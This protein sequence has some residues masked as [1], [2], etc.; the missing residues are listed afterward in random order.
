MNYV[1]E[2]HK[3]LYLVQKYISIDDEEDSHDV[4]RRDLSSPLNANDDRV[5]APQPV[6]CTCFVRRFSPDDDAKKVRRHRTDNSNLRKRRNVG[7][8]AKL[9]NKST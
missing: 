5:N 3:G 6:L 9:V 2:Y 1:N 4:D 8:N 7:I